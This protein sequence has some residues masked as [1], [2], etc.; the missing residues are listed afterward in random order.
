[1]NAEGKTREEI[2]AEREAK[3]LAKAAGKNKTK[4]PK[5]NT[6]PKASVKKCENHVRITSSTISGDH[7]QTVSSRTNI[8]DDVQIISSP[9]N[10][11]NAVKIISLDNYSGDDGIKVFTL[12]SNSQDHVQ[13]ESSAISGKCKPQNVLSDDEVEK[14]IPKLNEKFEKMTVSDQ[15]KV[16]K[17][18]VKAEVK[19]KAELR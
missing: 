6:E 16:S 2:K 12:S 4:A 17:P 5:E 9:T 19:S 18:E 14:E 15:A 11:T 8:D 3:K 10:S 13:V 7:A 1:M